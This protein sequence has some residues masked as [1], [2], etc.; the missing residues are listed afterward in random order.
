MQYIILND[1]FTFI[2]SSRTFEALTWAWFL[3]R[4]RENN[5][6]IFAELPFD[7]FS[8]LDALISILDIGSNLEDFDFAPK[9]GEISDINLRLMSI[10]LKLISLILVFFR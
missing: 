3:D 9:T 4:Y 5:E 1:I 8:D 6:N 10:V 7:N 2:N